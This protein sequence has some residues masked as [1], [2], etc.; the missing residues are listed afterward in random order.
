MNAMWR[1]L[2]HFGGPDGH[3]ESPSCDRTR[4]SDDRRHR[5]ELAAA[6][7]APSDAERASNTSPTYLPGQGGCVQD[8]G[9]GRV[10]EG[11]D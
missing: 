5:G 1:D 10:I 9:Y 3:R 11:C 2:F 4:L 6:W 7:R 8:L